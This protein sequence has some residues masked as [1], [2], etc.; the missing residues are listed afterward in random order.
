MKNLLVAINFSDLAPEIIANAIEMAKAMK[1]KIW[2][3][4]VADPNPFFIGYEVEPPVLRAQREEELKRERQELDAMSRQIGSHGIDVN[5][6]LLLG[7]PVASIIE[8]AEEIKA[9]MI[10]IGKED[11]GFFYKTFMGSTSEGVVS[12]SSC[13]V[14]VIPQK[15]DD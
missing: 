1:A 12:K 15:E 9:D 2:L 5:T 13:P 8:K 10:I 14:L 3:V 7:A 4:H 6:E 11:H